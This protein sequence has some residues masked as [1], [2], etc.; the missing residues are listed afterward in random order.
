MKIDEERGGETA[1]ATVTGYH[2]P[3]P[4]TSVASPYVAKLPLQPGL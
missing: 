2:F 4:R 3:K 1:P